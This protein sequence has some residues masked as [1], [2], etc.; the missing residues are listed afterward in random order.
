MSEKKRTIFR[1]QALDRLSSPER[2]DHLMQVV[3]PKDWLSLGGLAVFG[4]L[5]VLWSVFGNIPI[6]VTGKGVLINPRKVVQFQSPISGQVRSLNVKNGQ[7]VAKDDILATIDPSQQKQQLQQ[8]RDK[9]TQLQRQVQETTL[10]RQQRTQLE[11]GTITAERTSLTQRLQ[12]NQKLAPR[13]QDEG[14]NSISQQRLS[15]Q[16][17]LKDVEELTPVLQKRVEKQRELQKQGAISEEQVLQAEQEYRQTRQNIS[18]IKAQLQQLRVQETE[19]Q[20]KYLEN[21]NNITQINAELEKL[22]TRSKQL[23]QNNL[24][25]VN[26]EKNQIQELQQA[27]ARWEQEV[28][29]NSTIKS[30]H[31]GCIVEITAT[32]GQYLSPGNRLGTLQ[33]SGQASEMMSVAYFRVQDGKQIKPGMPILITP[34][35]VKRARFGGIVGEI[36]QVSAFPVTSEGASSVVGNPELVQKVM[37]GEGGKIEAIAQLK[38]D[39]KTFSGYKW[40]SSNGPKLAISPGTTTTVRVT[41]E[42]RSPI[43]F[44]LPILKE[45]SGIENL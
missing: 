33:T 19:Q 6:T 17:R 10:L 7:C 25:A 31:A 13:L 15:L 28:A 39:P 5:G 40:S 36:K 16:E 20:Q 35:T 42:E 27:I 9:L 22:N 41:V 30:P 2:L 37:D 29:E 34:D 44:V 14:L 43:T 11:T 21:N 12:D 1:Q 26:T 45:W 8:Q 3:N 4:V 18:E 24:E 32:V 23:E 38:L